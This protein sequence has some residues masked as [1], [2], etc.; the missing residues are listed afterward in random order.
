MSQ[1]SIRHIDNASHRSPEERSISPTPASQH[2]H[3]PAPTKRPSSILERPIKKAHTVV[4]T[5][6]QVFQDEPEVLETRTIRSVERVHNDLGQNILR[7]VISVHYVGHA[8]K[9]WPSWP[10]SKSPVMHEEMPPE[11]TGLVSD[12][13]RDQ[14]HLPTVLTT[15]W[16]VVL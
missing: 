6:K 2:D 5:V 15:P 1:S 10:W 12:L 13:C 3:R 11:M 9:Q 4:E 14:S 8:D 7:T 16:V